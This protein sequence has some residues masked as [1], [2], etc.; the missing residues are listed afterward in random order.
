M[1]AIGA[2]TATS[3]FEALAESA[4][5]AIIS[6]DA[7][8]TIL[9]ANS[10]V[11]DVFGYE[12]SDLIGRSLLLLIPP[13]YRTLHVEALQ[14]H[15]RTVDG[16][17][18]R[19]NLRLPALRKDGTEVP[20]EISFGEFM[21]ERGRRVFSGFIRDLTERYEEERAL[22]QVRSDLTTHAT[23]VD[24]LELAIITTDANGIV[25]TWNR[26]A[27]ALYGRTA[28]NAIGVSLD[29]V[30]DAIDA[31]PA[32]A[33]LVRLRNGVKVNYECEV[34]RGDGSLVWV[35]VTAAPIVDSRGNVMRI[36]GASVDIT[37]RKLMELQLLQAQ[38]MDAMGR[39]AGGIA[40]D[41]N[42]ILTVISTSADFLG[43][44]V[45]PGSEAAEDVSRISRA[46][47]TG[48]T[49]TRQLLTFTRKQRSG[50]E[51]RTP[52][53]WTM[54][55]LEQMLRRLIPANYELVLD[56]AENVPD[57]AMDRGQFEQVIINLVV[58]ARDAMP[59]GG[60]ITIVTRRLTIERAATHTD[61]ARAEVA[62]GVEDH[63]VGMTPEIRDRVFEPFFT[64]KEAGK[65]TGLGLATVNGI[66]KQAHG[67][68]EIDTAPGVG[69]TVWLYLPIYEAGD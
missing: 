41:F 23:L 52:V 48:G 6:I 21:D 26:Y 39:L 10:A 45:P 61:P 67:R 15:A 27:E 65:G 22:H 37:E 29:H 1:S 58:N 62:I 18:A 59:A 2:R 9:W 30:I 63:G 69:T 25:Q 36:I 17:V 3:L 19:R 5:D 51:H 57:L 16:P 12:R 55:E 47:R 14:R 34:R 56:L 46:A 40:H 49:L 44:V 68:I 20:V 43:Q 50:G 7:D 60:P 42:N 66:V 24:S 8:S 35:D 54:M 13:E 28:E 32:K 53:N 38:K 4:P 64:T 33:A 11:R 31:G